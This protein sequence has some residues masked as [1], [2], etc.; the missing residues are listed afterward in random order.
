[1]EE[2]KMIAHQISDHLKCISG[3]A[4]SICVQG[5]SMLTKTFSETARVERLL[6]GLTDAVI[7][8]TDADI[9]C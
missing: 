3:W 8:S 2:L 7:T 1:M 4:D 5:T 6:H 9:L